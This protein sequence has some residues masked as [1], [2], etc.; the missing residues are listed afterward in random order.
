M[1]GLGM[2][3]RETLSKEEQAAIASMTQHPGW[4]I[5]T[6]KLIPEINR[7][8]QQGMIEVKPEDPDYERKIKAAQIMA[9]S[10][11]EVSKVLIRSIDVHAS[12]A[13]T[14][15]ADEDDEE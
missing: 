15:K 13:L 9:R 12:A 6:T 2:L 1:A 11:D 8:A 5:V 7:Q 14:R 10:F 3:A 4:R